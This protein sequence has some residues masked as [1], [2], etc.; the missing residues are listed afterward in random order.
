MLSWRCKSQGSFGLLVV[1]IALTVGAAVALAQEKGVHVD[2][3]SPAGTEYAVPT[4]AARREGLPS[5]GQNGARPGSTPLFGA[6]IRAS[7]RGGGADRSASD[8]QVLEGS[9]PDARRSTPRSR[10]RSGD[11]ESARTLAAISTRDGLSP[12]LLTALIA[13]GVLLVGGVA[14]LLLRALR[15]G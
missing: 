10:G 4:D 12:E 8:G 14:A 15:C 2:P 11:E 9:D 3:D 7:G 13:L 1:V 6:G 5:S